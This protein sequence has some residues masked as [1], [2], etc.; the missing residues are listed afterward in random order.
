MDPFSDPKPSEG[1]MQPS[2]DSLGVFR[3]R[4]NAADLLYLP[5]QEQS[6]V[7]PEADRRGEG[8]QDTTADVLRV[9]HPSTFAARETLSPYPES[10]NGEDLHIRDRHGL[11]DQARKD[12][13]GGRRGLRAP[14]EGAEILDLETDGRRAITVGK[15]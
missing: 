1:D 7:Q 10:A 4:R 3:A 12:A 13:A 6:I 9:E 11:D 2:C 14:A 8:D 15:A 5:E